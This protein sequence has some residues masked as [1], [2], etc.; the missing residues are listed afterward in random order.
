MT[1]IE[2]AEKR[3]IPASEGEE[4]TGTTSAKGPAPEGVGP[5]VFSDQR[6]H[7]LES[8]K[9]YLNTDP[10]RV[11][12]VVSENDRGQT[13][14]T[15]QRCPRQ[16]GW[17][18]AKCSHR[19]ERW[20]RPR[21]KTYGCRVCG[22]ARRSLCVQ[23]IATGFER[24]AVD[25][26]AFI[27]L[28]Y[29]RQPLNPTLDL[30]QFIRWLRRRMPGLQYAVVRELTK[31]G[32]LHFHIIVSDW[33]YVHKTH[34]KREWYRITGN[35]ITWVKRVK[36]NQKARQCASYIGKYLMKRESVPSG[37]AVSYSQGWPSGKSGER[38]DDR[39]EYDYMQDETPAALEDGL[40]WGQL[41]MHNLLD[42]RDHLDGVVCDCYEWKMRELE[43]PDDPVDAENVGENRLQYRLRLA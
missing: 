3:S 31:R 4:L 2:S 19:S 29:R 20:V 13:K 23:R 22:P 42:V 6:E 18:R 35:Y 27:T 41:V 11:G 28:T 34:I 43:V 38:W 26:G 25:N 36:G 7:V 14:K 5:F 17:I 39:I 21:C 32:V 30:Q 40:R 15:P 9:D 1:L 16:S 33:K 37:K 12:G 24:L 10:V 8:K